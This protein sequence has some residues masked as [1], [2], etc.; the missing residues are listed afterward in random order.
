VGTTDDLTIDICFI[1]KFLYLPSNTTGWW[2]FLGSG[3]GAGL[4]PKEVIVY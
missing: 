2:P 4:P 1:T 3:R